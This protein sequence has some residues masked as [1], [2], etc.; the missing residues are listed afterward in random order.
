[1]SEQASV[2]TALATSRSWTKDRDYPERGGIMKSK[3]G[4]RREKK[5]ACGRG[6]RGEGDGYVFIKGRCVTK[7]LSLIQ[8]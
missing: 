2:D 1:M 4:S 8:I 5:G 7:G 3:A 6:K